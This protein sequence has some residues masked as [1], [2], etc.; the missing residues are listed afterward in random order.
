MGRWRASS[1]M[2]WPAASRKT[3]RSGLFSTRTRTAGVAATIAAPSSFT[4]SVPV[5]AFAPGTTAHE[6]S[7]PKAP[8]RD[9]RT[10]T[11]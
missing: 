7:L 11:T 5:G 1:L 9:A 10:R 4:V 3:R 2:T 6:K 8:S